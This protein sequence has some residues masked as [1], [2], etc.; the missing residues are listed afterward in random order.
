[1]S[2]AAGVPSVVYTMADNQLPSAQAF[3]QAGLVLYAGDIR[4]DRDTTCRTILEDL[5]DLAVDNEKRLSLAGKI[6]QKIDGH[7]AERIAQAILQIA[8]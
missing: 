1:M 7:G 6:R 3:A 8:R 2:C 4:P 5:S